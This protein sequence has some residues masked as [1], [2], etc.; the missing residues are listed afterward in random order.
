MLLLSIAVLLLYFVSSPIGV[1]SLS[2]VSLSTP[3]RIYMFDILLL[4]HSAFQEHS[5]IA[6]TIL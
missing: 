2:L 1:G 3:D 6:P 5:E 4:K